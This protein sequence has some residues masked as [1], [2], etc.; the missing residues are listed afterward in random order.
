MTDGRSTP[1]WNGRRAARALDEVKRKGRARGEPCCICK[2]PIDY[3]LPSTDPD[4]CSV[5]HVKSRALFPHLTWDPANWSPA[6]LSCNKAEGKTAT[7]SIGNTSR[8]W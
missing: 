1:A 4:G 5:Q 3:D 2:Q 8:Q 7:V 6:H